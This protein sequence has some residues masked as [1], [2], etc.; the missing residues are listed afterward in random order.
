MVYTGPVN[1]VGDFL[2]RW[3]Y[4]ASPALDGVSIHGT[5]QADGDVRDMM[6]A[7]N[8]ELL[9]RHLMFKLIVPHVLTR[10]QAKAA[11]SPRATG[12][13]PCVEPP[14]AA[15]P[16]GGGHKAE[17]KKLRTLERIIKIQKS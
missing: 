10:Y 14:R 15:A 1:P 8:E 9:A 11:P 2:A 13:P 5:A 17:E 16:V 12:A 3:A 4:P 7:D 6:P